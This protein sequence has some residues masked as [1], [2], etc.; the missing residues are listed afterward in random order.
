PILK[1]N[2]TLLSHA[3]NLPK[4]EILKEISE[5]LSSR[6]KVFSYQDSPKIDALNLNKNKLKILFIL[7]TS[8][9]NKTYPI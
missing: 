3:L 2:F 7:E 8:K 4:K 5:G 6:S 9:I 1:R